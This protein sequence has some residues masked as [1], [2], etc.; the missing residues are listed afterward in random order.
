[1]TVAGF[2]NLFVL[3]GP[4]TNLGHNSTVF[5]VECQVD[6]I[7]QCVRRLAERRA[8]GAA[9]M[10]VRRD[11]MDAF[12]RD[13]QERMRSTVWEAGCD[14]WYK[15]ATGKVINN[16]PSYTTEYRRRTRTPN[17]E[18]YVFTENRLDPAV[19]TPGWELEGSVRRSPRTQLPLGDDEARAA[20]AVDVDAVRA[21]RIEGAA[22]ADD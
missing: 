9:A 14:S 22:T 7:L 8:G 4:N 11:V 16:W 5:M 13:V 21:R 19:P 18:E 1:M 6:Y 15:T 10:D 17:F 3:Y 12:N 20:K 2:P